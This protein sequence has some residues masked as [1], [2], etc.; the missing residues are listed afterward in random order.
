MIEL[1]KEV[2]I[3]LIAS[4]ALIYSGLLVVKAL[5][6]ISYKL[7][8]KEYILTFV[9]LAFSTSIPELFVGIT[10]ALNKNPSLS[11]G[12]IIGANILDSTFVI[13]IALIIARNFKVSGNLARSTSIYAV[14][15]ASFPVLLGPIGGELSRIDGGL[16]MLSF[17]IYMG[18][19]LKKSKVRK[20][21]I[22]KKDEKAL[23]DGSNMVD[24]GKIKKA[25]LRIKDELFF[26]VFLFILGMIAV[27]FSAKYV[28]SSAI[29]ISNTLGLPS[30]LVGMIIVSIGTTL[31][32]L[33]LEIRIAIAKIRGMA[34]GDPIGSIVVNSTFILG[35]VALI[36][37]IETSSR[38]FFL[39]SMFTIA[40]TSILAILLN[41]KKQLTWK[42][43]LMLLLLYFIF[44]II[45]LNADVLNI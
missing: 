6:R 29:D 24:G 13:A 23:G 21:A 9:L 27:F 16:L 31:P 30:I 37:P 20:Q 8:I 17:F 3:L 18:T 38:E 36:Q 39:G 1:V 28:T 11:L 19:V 33:M 34:F 2:A 42:H 32:E 12:N 41:T 45:Q 10:S 35:L 22:E 26:N 7:R 40:A 14:G 15:M 4:I 5:V 44:L 25:Y 43:G